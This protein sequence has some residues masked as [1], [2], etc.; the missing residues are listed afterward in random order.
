[1]ND[2]NILVVDDNSNTRI[3]IGESLAEAGYVPHDAIDGVSALSML[4]ANA[5]DLVL[6]D[7]IMPRMSGFEVCREI[8]E[9]SSVPIIMLTAVGDE[10]AKIESLQLGADDYVT[11]PF[12]SPELMARI[13]A[14]LRRVRAFG[15][16]SA[17]PSY[18]GD[19]LTVDFNAHRVVIQGDEVELTATEFNLLREL[20]QNS[21]QVMPHR[22][23]LQRVWGEEYGD[24]REYLRVFVNRLRHKLNDT[25]TSP[26]YIKTVPGVGY[27]FI[28]EP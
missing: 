4:R 5:F 2:I 20:I 16:P 23:L 19:G 26:R 17:T 25:P 15:M 24:E 10:G 6:L 3:S 28:G 13:E 12:S 21:G 9:T 27:Q 1:M 22:S 11:K 18:S 8:R 14:V 7:M